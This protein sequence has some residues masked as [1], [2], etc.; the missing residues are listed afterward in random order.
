MGSNALP[1]AHNRTGER[2]LPVL[3]MHRQPGRSASRGNEAGSRGRMGGLF[4]L[5]YEWKFQN[6]YPRID[7]VQP[8]RDEGG[9]PSAADVQPPRR[10]E[11]AESDA[12]RPKVHIGQAFVHE[13]TPVSSSVIWPAH[14]L[15]PHGAWP[16]ITTEDQAG[17][18][19][20]PRIVAQT[21]HCTGVG[22]ASAFSSHMLVQQETRQ[23]PHQEEASSWQC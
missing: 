3:S 11:A 4:A 10:R 6:G 9:L 22:K 2:A 17:T 18:K 7:D 21:T 12:D 14:F 5:S 1:L 13:L 15:G 19:S 23:S 8:Q 20:Y 16:E